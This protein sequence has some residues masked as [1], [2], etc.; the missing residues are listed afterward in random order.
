MESSFLP[1]VEVQTEA[2]YN[3]TACDDKLLV[4][5]YRHLQRVALKRLVRGAAAA[6]RAGLQ[7]M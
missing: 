6:C 1:E 4:R 5:P 7:S 2:R 3:D